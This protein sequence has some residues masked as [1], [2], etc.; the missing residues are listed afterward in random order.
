ML[1]EYKQI[2]KESIVDSNLHDLDKNEL[3]RQYVQTSEERYLSA[4]IYKFWYI[5]INKISN[6]KNNKFIEPEDFYGMFIDSI[7]DTCNNALWNDPAHSLYGDEKAP[8]KS[9]NT[10]FNSKIINYF[11]ACNRQKRKSIYEKVSLTDYTPTNVTSIQIEHVLNVEKIDKIITELFNKKD[12]YSSYILDL[13][14]NNDTFD[15]K[16]GVSTFNRKK[17]KKL[18]MNI[19]TSYCEYFAERYGLDLN[20]VLYSLKYISGMSY[21]YVDKKIDISM[22]A[23]KMN[24]ELYCM[25]KG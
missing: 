17:L 9:I 8:E 16:D 11:H 18:L 2:Y 13:V 21:D 23:L 24:K 1:E 3:I 14:V 15:F 12:Y 6:N 7:M 5:L 20:K 4:A 19:D 10:I 22:N 25:R